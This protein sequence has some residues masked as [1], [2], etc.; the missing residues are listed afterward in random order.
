M[1]K[2][3]NLLAICFAVGGCAVAP[4]SPPPAAAE[5]APTCELSWS[6]Q[7]VLNAEWQARSLDRAITAQN[8]LP[9]ADDRYVRFRGYDADVQRLEG[10]SLP[11]AREVRSAFIYLQA[12]EQL[13]QDALGVAASPRSGMPQPVAAAAPQAAP[14]PAPAPPTAAALPTVPAPAPAPQNVPRSTPV[15]AI[16]LVTT[17]SP[18]MQGPSSDARAAESQRATT[19]AAQ[20]SQHGVKGLVPGSVVQA[21]RDANTDAAAASALTTQ[22]LQKGA[23]DDDLVAIQSLPGNRTLFYAQAWGVRAIVSGY[24]SD[25]I[26]EGTSLSQLNATYFRVIGSEPYQTAGGASSRAYVITPAW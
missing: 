25:R 23:L 16:P 19:F 6:P 3:F 5:S 10:C 20:A 21:L 24:K 14:A 26:S 12:R 11:Q 4:Q 1:P 2:H 8:A 9:Q 7:D 18:S 13:R 22:A 17:P 15:A